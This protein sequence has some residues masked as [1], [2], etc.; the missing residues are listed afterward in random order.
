MYVCKLPLTDPEPASAQGHAG[1][2]A[3]LSKTSSCLQNGEEMLS[4]CFYTTTGWNLL[5]NYRLGNRGWVG[6][7]HTRR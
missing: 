7:E 5:S 2:L 4:F 1:E 3:A 6:L